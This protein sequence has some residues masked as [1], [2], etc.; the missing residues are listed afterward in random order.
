M[1]NNN[2]N[3][4]VV[5]RLANLIPGVVRTKGGTRS[6]CDIGSKGCVHFS[7]ASLVYGVSPPM[8][9]PVFPN[10]PVQ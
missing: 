6:Y 7:Y 4:N 5:E 2:D 8:Y 3:P 9:F 10:V 1:T